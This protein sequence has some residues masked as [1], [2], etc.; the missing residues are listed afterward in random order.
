MVWRQL[1]MMASQNANNRPI[2]HCERSAPPEAGKRGNLT[3][4]RLVVR[5]EHGIDHSPGAL[6][7]MLLHKVFSGE[8]TQAELGHA[9]NKQAGPAP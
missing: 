5:V 9:H 2:C 1:I 7:R 3:V 4:I 8:H 6:C